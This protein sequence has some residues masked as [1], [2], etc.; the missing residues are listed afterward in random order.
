MTAYITPIYHQSTL[1]IL[2]IFTVQHIN[3]KY[4]GAHEKKKSQNA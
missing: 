4:Y 3:K 1:G 2:I